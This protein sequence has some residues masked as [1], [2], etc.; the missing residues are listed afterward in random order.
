VKLPLWRLVAG[1]AVLGTLVA[2]LGVAG[3]A[4]LDNYRLDNYMR[5][6]AARSDLNDA[7]LTADILRHAKDL[8]LPVQPY[9]I[10]IVRPDGRP[11]IRIARYAMQTALAKLDLRMPEASSR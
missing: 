11:H 9:D 4:Y 6:L 2:L 5:T 1:I 10:Q 7:E 3:L 8:N